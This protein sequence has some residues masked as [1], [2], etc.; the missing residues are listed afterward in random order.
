MNQPTSIQMLDAAIWQEL[1]GEKAH[2]EIRGSAYNLNY[3]PGACVKER[4]RSA[5][6]VREVISHV[7]RPGISNQPLFSP[8]C[9]GS[10]RLPLANIWKIA[11]SASPLF[12]KLPEPGFHSGCRRRR[13]QMDPPLLKAYPYAGES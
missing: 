1:G 11:L 10:S 8:N 9:S 5:E 13:N 2:D 3:S 12:K 4:A 7:R 6:Q